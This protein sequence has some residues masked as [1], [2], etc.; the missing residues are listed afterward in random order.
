MH[1]KNNHSD[2]YD[3]N[4]IFV[5]LASSLEQDNIDIFIVLNLKAKIKKLDLKKDSE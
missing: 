1:K 2:T 4:L 3:K 5:H